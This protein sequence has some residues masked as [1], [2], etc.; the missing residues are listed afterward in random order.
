MTLNS[1]TV[2]LVPPS[3]SATLARDVRARTRREL[4]RTTCATRVVRGLSA[5]ASARRDDECGRDAR[6]TGTGS[7]KNLKSSL[8]HRQSFPVTT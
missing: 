7:Q 3:R 6:A 1:K 5:S 2:R 8:H 4:H